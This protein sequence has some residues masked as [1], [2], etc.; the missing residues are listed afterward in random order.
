M[1]K[2]QLITD[3]KQ[4]IKAAGLKTDQIELSIPEN[5]QFGDY[6]TNIALQQSNLGSKNDYQSAQDIASKIIEKLGHPV[7]L[8]RVD[9]A[10][11]GFINF[12]IKDQFL[13]QDLQQEVPLKGIKPGA[14]KILVEYASP[15]AA[16]A[17]H[18]GQLRN[19]ISG[20]AVARL[21]EYLGKEVFRAT[22]PS[23]TGL[24]MAKVVWFLLENPDQYQKSKSLDL[25]AKIELLGQIYV[26]ANKAYEDQP[27]A[28]AEIDQINKKI[29]QKDQEV[30]VVWQEVRAWSQ[31][32]TEALY[33]RV[34]TEFD[35]TIWESEVEAEGKRIVEENIG[36]IFIE[37]EGA[38]VFP[39]EKFGLHT[40]VFITSAGN[41]TYE[42]KELGVTIREEEA[43]GFDREIHIVANEQIDYFKVVIKVVEL[44]DQKMKNRKF[45]LPYGFVNLTSGKM[46]SREGNVVTAEALIDLVREQI[47]NEYNIVAGPTQVRTAEK[48]A[49]AAIKFSYLKYSLASDISFD[50]KQSISLQGDSGPYVL[51]ANARVN[52]LLKT[53]SLKNIKFEPGN[54]KLEQEERSILRQ[55]E[56]FNLVA[57][58]AADNFQPSEL[59]TY[60]L[61]L[62]KA[63]NH[64]YE[65][66][67]VIGSE[68]ESFRLSLVK[69]VGEVLTLGLFLLGIESVEK[70]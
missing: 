51:Y 16:K 12:Y 6:S 38:V 11:P 20:E 64:F 19:L 54:I 25:Q 15:N 37:S 41:P 67:P 7:Y 2:D 18:I 50:I 55:L 1:V 4:A 33:T 24:P 34:G 56:Y 48:I 60:L 46:S 8:E 58:K 65:I 21:L 5:E 13:I 61:K 39:G 17:L 62:A 45:H 36:K 9:L 29:H 49:L 59:T 42:A 27:E 63:F 3:L 31:A 30:L 44:I 57:S 28:K 68:K 22:Y 52:S 23:D 43:F 32:Y 47:L 66:Y 14:E 10:G 35:L 70:M 26:E 69:K 40:R 53:S